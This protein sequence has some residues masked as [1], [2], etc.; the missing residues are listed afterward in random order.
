MKENQKALKRQ[1]MAQRQEMEA[2][3]RVKVENPRE[4]ILVEAV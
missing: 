2:W 3:R 1:N 4:V